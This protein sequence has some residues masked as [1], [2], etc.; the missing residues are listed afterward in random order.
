MSELKDV[1]VNVIGK[2]GY[3]SD[4]VS[5]SSSNITYGPCNQILVR[6]SLRGLPFAMVDCSNKAITIYATIYDD[7][8]C[9][10]DERLAITIYDPD[11]F[12]KIETCLRERCLFG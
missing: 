1:M 9:R 2:L 8:G 6:R 4:C 11:S 5:L 10:F 3:W 12:T 7:G